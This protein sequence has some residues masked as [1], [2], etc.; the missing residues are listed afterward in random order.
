MNVHNTDK[1]FIVFGR[2]CVNVPNASFPLTTLNIPLETWTHVGKSVG[3][4]KSWLHQY[5]D[6]SCHLHGVCS[7]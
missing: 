2:F 7:P 5:D 6:I 3:K 1:I 4:R